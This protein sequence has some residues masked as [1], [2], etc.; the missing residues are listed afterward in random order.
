MTPRQATVPVRAAADLTADEFAI[1]RAVLYASLF[2]YPLTL[3]QLRASLIER[4]QT[5]AGLLSAY[6]ESAAL[7]AVID[8]REGFFF[9]RGS[10]NP[11]AERLRRERASR[12]LLAQHRWLL[13]L[14]CALPFTRLVA[15]SGS[16]AHLNVPPGGGDIDLFIVT[17]G[18]RVWSV[19]LTILAIARLLGRRDLVCVNFVVADS[20]MRLDQ[21]DLFSANQI[22]HLKPLAG[23]GFYAAFVQANPCVR[24][25]YPNFEPAAPPAASRAARAAGGLKRSIEMA[26]SCGPAQ[27]Y[28]RLC[29]AVYGRHLRRR[30][31]TW[32]SP[33]QVRL[34]PDCLK[35]HTRSHRH[36]IMERFEALVA[37]SVESIA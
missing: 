3:A 19:T 8:Y 35:L 24:Q 7:Q 21:Q 32:P 18:R 30:A 17:R 1:L 27:A 9:C 4:R 11:P 29:R 14:V 26:L 25:C 34:L 10:Q 6:Q 22:M 5:E 20:A 16:V 12:A 2:D 36:S 13:R 31:A 15:L 37:A 33:D 28:D 23:S